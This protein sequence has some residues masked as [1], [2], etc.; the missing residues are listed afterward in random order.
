MAIPVLHHATAARA[1]PP[2]RPAS[3][4]RFSARALSGSDLEEGTVPPSRI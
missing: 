1:G 4:F 2:A 3:H